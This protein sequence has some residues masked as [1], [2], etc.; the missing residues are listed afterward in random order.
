MS[1]YDVVVAGLG[2]FGSSTAA[3]LARRGLRTLGLDPR[4]AA[5]AEGA[6][7]GETRIVRQVYFEGA[8]YVPLLRRTYELWAE[9]ADASGEPMLRTHR[10]AVPR[11]A[12]HPGPPRQPGDGAGWDLPH[13]VL[14][15]A[16]VRARFPA[17]R[18]PEGVVGL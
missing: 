18:P 10:R 8:S 11:P 2:G 4:P 13:E 5:H 1:T 14:D 6:S 17:L 3:H 9:L 7:H 16:E 12:A 15:G